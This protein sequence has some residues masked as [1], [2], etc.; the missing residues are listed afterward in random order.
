MNKDQKLLE[1]AYKAIY[2]S[3]K[4][5]LYFG[6]PDKK[7]AFMKWLKKLKHEVH[8][9]GSVSIDGEVRFML[10]ERGQFD[11]FD[12][13]GQYIVSRLPF[14]FRKV[15]G[16]FLCP[17]L[18]RSLTG[19]PRHVG[20]NFISGPDNQNIS[21]LEGAPDYIGKGFQCMSTHLKSLEGAPEVIN[22][23]FGTK[24]FSKDDYIDMKINRKLSKNFSEE[25]LKTLEDFS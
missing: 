11:A 8:E 19:S 23:Y 25:Q 20:G 24:W 2:E 14:N 1:E 17:N 18:L 5:P 3:L 6:P 22:G 9:D 16:D 12:N 7:E 21:S 10:N 4:E 15:T 13:L